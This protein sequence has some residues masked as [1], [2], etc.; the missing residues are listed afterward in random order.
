MKDAS[1]VAAV[2]AMCDL[3][4]SPK[5]TTYG[6]KGKGR[7]KEIFDTAFTPCTD[8]HCVVSNARTH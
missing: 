5:D 4:T 7:K 3:V 2:I 8:V 6:E 1:R